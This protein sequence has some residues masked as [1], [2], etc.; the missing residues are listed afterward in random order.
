MYLYRNANGVCTK[1]ELLEIALKGEFDEQYL[2]T[3]IKRIREEIENDP[4]H[5]RFLITEPNT[6]YKLILDP[7]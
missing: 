7:K 5:P 4:K 2:P 3:L 1:K 6:G